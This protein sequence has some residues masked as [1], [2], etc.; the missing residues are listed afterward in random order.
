MVY[1]G[2]KCFLPTL[3]LTQNNNDSGLSTVRLNITK[4]EAKFTD[5]IVNLNLPLS[6]ADTIT[7]TMKKALPDSEIAR[8]YKC[9]RSKTT[10]MVNTVEKQE[11][12][13][14]EELLE[15]QP[16][17][18]STDGS[19]DQRDKQFPVVITAVGESGVRQHLLTVPI[20]YD[21]ATVYK[22]SSKALTDR[23]IPISNSIS[24]GG[25]GMQKLKM[26]P[27]TIQSTV[28]STPA[29]PIYT[30]I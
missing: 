11:S 7:K 20:L 17:S 29:S 27:N 4:A 21:S 13:T 1:Y 15:T 5:L 3:F 12:A 9:S 18:L 30:H 28:P 10:A 25:G 2:K 14:I 16:Y 24:T 19:N 22:L 26:I 8:G 6:A 23:N